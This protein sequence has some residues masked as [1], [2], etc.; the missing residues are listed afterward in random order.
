MQAALRALPVVVL[1]GAR[2]VGKTTLAQ[3]ACPPARTFLTLDDIGVLG[4]AQRD[5]DS[6]LSARPL[7]LDEVQRAPE[8]LLAVKRQVDRRRTAGDFLLTG[9]ANLLLLGTVADSLAGRAVYIDLPPFCPL[10]WLGRKDGLAPFDLLFQPDF[11]LRDWPEASGEWQWWL[12][13]GGFPSA[14]MAPTEEARRFWFAGYVQT[15]LERDLRQLSDVSNLPDF[16]RLMTVA[17][18]R[19]GRLVNQSDM[20]RDAGLPQ[21]TAHRYLNLIETGC[22]ITRLPPYA[23]NPATGL[24]KAKKL[25]WNDGGL[26]AWLAGIR[27]HD[28]LVERNDLGF[29]L[30]QAVYQTL[31]TWRSLDPAGRRLHYWRDR[32]GHEVDFILEQEGTLV[33][34]EIK[35][36][37]MATLSDAR[38]LAAFKES[39][40]TRTVLRRSVVLHGGP[41]R[42]LGEDAFALPWGWMFPALPA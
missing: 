17:A 21:A 1:T 14:L 4:Q 36:G 7:T 23:T 32:T 31:Q 25:F 39:L 10:E 33:A 2:Q 11:D 13:S 16:Q 34:L 8:V 6:L 41:A 26:A 28:Q 18:N 24:V 42:P 15:Y 29:W 3:A 5:P 9:S 20:G 30:E 19:T 12:R 40:G 38:G 37:S 27:S 35:A 22:L